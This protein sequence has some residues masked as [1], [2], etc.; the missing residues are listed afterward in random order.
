MNMLP[1]E[2]QRLGLA[3]AGVEQEAHHGDGDRMIRFRAVERPTER[4]ELV[5]RQVVRLEA[6]LAPPQSLARVGVLAPQSER[7]GVL[8]HRRQHRQRPVRRSRARDG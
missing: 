1:L 8:H 2:P 4:G 5:V 6:R 7:L 3:R